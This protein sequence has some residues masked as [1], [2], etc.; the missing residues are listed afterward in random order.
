[1]KA[2]KLS[3]LALMLVASAGHA[4]IIKYN[5][6]A[7]GTSV[8]YGSTNPGD[9]PAGAAS[10]LLPQN[11]TLS[12]SFFYDTNLQATYSGPNYN[13]YISTTGIGINLSSSAGYQFANN[14]TAEFY[15]PAVHVDDSNPQD[16]IR[17]NA[18][19][20]DSHGIGNDVT[21]TLSGKSLLSLTQSSLPHSLSLND[22]TG[23]VVIY[24]GDGA[25]KEFNY[26]ATMDSL[27]L[28]AAV[29]EPETYALLLAGLGLIGVARRRKQQAAA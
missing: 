3:L 24:W 12:G 25:G 4:E 17:I 19:E 9:F 18:A 13:D 29:P 14:V 21:I 28:A 2:I 27:T 8:N 15:E 7:H 22:F 1:M 20:V 10:Y 16:L 23:E 11:S 5:F 26:L 6:T